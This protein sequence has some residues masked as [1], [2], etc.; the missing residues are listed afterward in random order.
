[1][2]VASCER[3]YSQKKKFLYRWT[4]L[5]YAKC[6][7]RLKAML[8]A[9]CSTLKNKACRG[10]VKWKPA[11]DN[12]FFLTSDWSSIDLWYIYCDSTSYSWHADRV[13]TKSYK[14]RL[15]FCGRCYNKEI[16]RPYWNPITVVFF[17]WC[18]EIR[19]ANGFV[20][21]RSSMTVPARKLCVCLSDF[22]C[23]DLQTVYKAFT[24]KSWLE[25]LRDE[26][27]IDT[28]SF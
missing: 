10:I 20:Q 6:L 5:T 13:L 15:N 19:K 24:T 22:F 27:K 23:V 3:P 9:S 17:Q 14:K 26:F 2:M 21:I 1:M 7:K 16:N 25:A 28:F 12:F 4:D 11:K 18:C 8:K